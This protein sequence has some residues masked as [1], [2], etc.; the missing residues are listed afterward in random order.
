MSRTQHWTKG[1]FMRLKGY[2]LA[3]VLI[4]LGI[5][6]IVAAITLSTLI[7]NIL[8]NAYTE[9]LKKAY[10]L[11]QQTTN[12]VAEDIGAEPQNWDFYTFRIMKII[13]KT[14]LY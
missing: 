3:E 2:T 11:L 4:T 9:R 12:F 10:S 13:Q 7:T 8:N 14:F 6:G 5:I 1:N